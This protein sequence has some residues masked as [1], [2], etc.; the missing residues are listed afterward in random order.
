MAGVAG[1]EKKAGAPWKG[2]RRGGFGIF[3]SSY[4]LSCGSLLAYSFCIFIEASKIFNHRP[5]IY[6]GNRREGFHDMGHGSAGRSVIDRMP[7]AKIVV[8]GI[9]GPG[10][11]REGTRSQRM[12][13]PTVRDAACKM[14]RTLDFSPKGISRR[15]TGATMTE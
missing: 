3:C 2:H 14:R 7:G 9:C 11:R 1:A 4:D 5:Y 6:I 15:M 8:K 10:D 13:I 12:G